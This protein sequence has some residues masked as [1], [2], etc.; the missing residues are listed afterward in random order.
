ML[1]IV[2]A[3]RNKNKIREIETILKEESSKRNP[4]GMDIQIMSLDDIG[5][6][7][8]IEETG[9]TF[10]ENAIIKASAVFKLGYI[11][12]ADDSGLA[13]DSLG[14]APGV[15]S[16]RYSGE[17]ANDEKNNLK[18]LQ[19]LSDKTDRSARFVS[20]IA[21][22]FPDETA[23]IIVRGECEGQILHEARGVGGFG[24]D[25]LFFYPPLS[26]S[27]AQLSAQEKNSV[28]HRGRAMREF[29]AVF[30]KTITNTERFNLC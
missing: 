30:S 8:E 17:G 13:V 26:K 2:L 20:V 12:I 23:P 3:S 16:A 15:Y 11:G 25:P 5:F 24:Y 29:A 7:D 22:V 14:G 1:K 21:C 9:S 27:F 18:L 4:G 19:E 10:E 6:F 28:S